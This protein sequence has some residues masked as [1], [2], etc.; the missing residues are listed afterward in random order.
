M[1]RLPSAYR[2]NHSCDS[3]MCVIALYI[4][5]QFSMACDSDFIFSSKHELFLV[6]INLGLK[7]VK[8]L[9]R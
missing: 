9:S 8:P 5:K 6:R 2:V 3:G 1:S 4:W 7:V